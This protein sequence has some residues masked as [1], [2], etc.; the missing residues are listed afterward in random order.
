MLFSRKLGERFVQEIRGTEDAFSPVLSPDGSEVL[1]AVGNTNVA[2][3]KRVDIR[4]GVA[5]TFAAS[6]PR[7]GQISWGDR[8]QIVMA[9]TSN[10]WLIDAETSGRTVL[11]VPDRQRNYDRYGFPSVLPGAKAALISI[12]RGGRRADSIVVGVVTIPGGKV[13]ELGLRGISPRYSATGHILY[14]T[15]AGT[16]FAVPFDASA[17]RVTGVP[18][19]IA[20]DV[21]G[22]SGGALPLAVAD[23]GTLAFIPGRDNEGQVRPAV[24]DRSGRQRLLPVPPAFYTNPR[25]SPDGRQVAYSLGEARLLAGNLEAPDIWRMDVVTGNIQRVTTNKASDRP[26]WS[27]DGTEILFS[28]APPD[29]NQFSIPLYANAQPKVVFHVPGILATSDIGPPHGYAVLGVVKPANPDLWI[30]PM[31][32]ASEARPFMAEPYVEGCRASRPTGIS[33]PIHRDGPAPARSTFASS[34]AAARK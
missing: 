9:D 19:A 22:G 5:R 30:V 14:A 13:T 29:S 10:L 34:P 15:T 6:G 21:Q 31:D 28:S 1:F 16:L 32:S 23:N 24:V 33:W 2:V 11:A 27:R 3:I 4:G 20:E 7:N 12:W 26:I 25:V 8:N 17:L 18:T